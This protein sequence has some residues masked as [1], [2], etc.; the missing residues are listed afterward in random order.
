MSEHFYPL[1]FTLQI[2]HFD[3]L[4]VVH[5]Q[6]YRLYVFERVLRENHLELV[7]TVS[8]GK[9]GQDLSVGELCAV[10]GVFFWEVFRSVFYEFFSDELLF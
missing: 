4:L 10:I 2:P 7:Y 9:F 3:I 8:R 6:V 1:F 5:V